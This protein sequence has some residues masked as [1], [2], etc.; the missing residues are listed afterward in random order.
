MTNTTRRPAAAQAGDR[1]HRAGDRLRGPATTTP[2][3]STEHGTRVHDRRTVPEARREPCR[4]NGDVP[5]FEPFRAVRYAPAVDLDDVIAPPYDVLSDADVDALEARDARNIV[6]VDVPRGGARPLRAGRPAA[7]GV[8]RRRR[9]G[10]RRRRRR[11]RSTA[12]GSPTPPGARAR[13]RR[14]ARRARGRRRGRR[15]RAPPRA[16]DAEGVDR[17]PRPD[18]GDDGQPVA[19][20][21]PVAGRRADRRCSPN[22]ASPSAP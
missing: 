3:R 16:H 20:V 2:S 19:G 15:R 18:A 8:D 5:R 12:C 22:R 10:P 9:D 21:G 4:Q 17:P 14:R 6:H 13:P 1:L 7:A 11:S